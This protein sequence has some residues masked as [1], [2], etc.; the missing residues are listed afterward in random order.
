M[1][2]NTVAVASPAPKKRH[3]SQKA[4]TAISTT[5]IYI[6]LIV[7]SILWILPILW[8]VL[9]SFTGEQQAS[10]G[11]FIPAIWDFQV[12]AGQANPIA[13]D[14]VYG[15]TLGPFGNYVQLFTN[16]RATDASFSQIV[17]SNF[18]FFGRIVNGRLSLGG[19]TN[20][21]FIATISTL[22]STLLVLCTSY[23]FS[24]LRFKGRT[25]MMRA[26]MVIGMFPGFLGLVILYN[27]FRILNSAG[28]G[29]FYQS[30]WGLILVYTGGAGMNYYISKGFFDTISKQIDEAAMVYGATRFQI[31]YKI[32][33]PLSKPIIIYTILT[34]FMSPWAEFIS[35]DYI[36]GP[37]N[38]DYSNTTVSLIL[39]RMLNKLDKASTPTYWGQF[40][41]GAVV[42][43][44]P[45]TILFMFMQKY[46][47]SGVTGGA[48]KG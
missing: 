27:L 39:Y 4:R 33:I 23:A 35:A 13:P 36:L 24:R 21:L 19:F 45:T 14:I 25:V 46:Y 7:M 8:I 30:I 2:T 15:T 6:I 41:A 17:P 29:L 20:T 18:N 26:I 3:A 10:F 48:V 22:L 40:C 38:P 11:K 44:L 47:V 28:I 43:A 12:V 42:I 1:R 16:V 34:S 9:Q 31:F 5:I 37:S 32:T